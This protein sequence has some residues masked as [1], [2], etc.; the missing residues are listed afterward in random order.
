MAIHKTRKLPFTNTKIFL[1][2]AV[3]VLSGLVGAYLITQSNAATTSVGAAPTCAAQNT[4]SGLPTLNPGSSHECVKLLQWSLNNLRY[5]DAAEGTVH[6]VQKSY[7]LNIS[8]QYDSATT[9][10]VIDFQRR[11]QAVGCKVT[12]GTGALN[13][14]VTVDGTADAAT[15]YLLTNLTNQPGFL[16]GSYTCG[17]GNPLN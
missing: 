13:Q 4:Q 17:P 14:S 15:W 1:P 3:M 9:D 12:A 16:S 8:G 6:T 2:V 10:A 11:M 5:T 7:D